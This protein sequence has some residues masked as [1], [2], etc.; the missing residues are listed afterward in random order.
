[1]KSK[2]DYKD[3]LSD[4]LFLFWRTHSTK[5]LDAFWG[6]FLKNNKELREPFNQAVEAYE[7]I[8][9]EQ[10]MQQ[11]NTSLVRQKLERR[12]A[13]QKRRK[14]QRIYTSSAVAVLLLALVS[15]LFVMV[16]KQ[17]NKGS[18][19]EKMTTI[20]QVMS[21]NKVQ[22]LAG[23]SILDIDNNSRLDLSEKENNAIIEDSLSRKEINLNENEVNKL[24]VPFGQ[25]TSIVLS[26]GSTIYLNSGTEMEFPTIF[27]GNKREISVKGEIFIETAKDE[28]TPFIIHTHYSQI[29][30]Y[31]TSFNVSSYSDENKE[32]VVL[33]NGSVEIK[34]NNTSLMLKPNEMAEIENGIIHHKQVD[35]TEYIGWKNGYMQFN[36][37]PLND[38]LKKIGRYYNVEFIYHSSTN[39]S[40]ETCSGKL[41]LSDNLDD[42]LEAFSKM[43]FFTYEKSNDEVIFINQQ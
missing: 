41:F 15:T 33:V 32:S 38:V 30:V 16:K 22:L 20:G 24:I 21:E 37:T 19:E 27:K 28:N 1:M 4:D 8:R 7:I 10:G 34:H 6:N 29:I 39:L 2:I 31:G 11:L 18:I 25:R 13:A 5:E 12:I 17:D 14:L 9:N 23:N 35:V 3:F 42:I 26:D 40:G 43:T 36:K